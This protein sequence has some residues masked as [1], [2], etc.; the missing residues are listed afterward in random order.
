MRCSSPHSSSPSTP[1]RSFAASSLP[2][3]SLAELDRYTERVLFADSLAA[4][5]AD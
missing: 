4:V 5:F 2:R 3:S 1:G